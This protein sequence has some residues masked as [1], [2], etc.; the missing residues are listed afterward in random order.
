MSCLS[1]RLTSCSGCCLELT[2]CETT[3]CKGLEEGF[4][5]VELVAEHHGLYW[6]IINANAM[7]VGGWYTFK[8]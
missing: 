5:I 8:L 4:W 3:F 7:V 1:F 6:E 2:Q